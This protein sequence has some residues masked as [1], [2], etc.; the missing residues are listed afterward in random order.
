MEILFKSEEKQIE[1]EDA[2]FYM[3]VEKEG[4]KFILSRVIVDDGEESE[5]ELESHGSLADAIDAANNY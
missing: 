1:G 2:C 3:Q 5:F 4:E